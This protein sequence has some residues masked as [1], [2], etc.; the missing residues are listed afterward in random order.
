MNDPTQ[1]AGVPTEA[2][3]EYSADRAELAAEIWAS[4]ASFEGEDA[5]AQRIIENALATS[6]A[7]AVARVE[8][9][10]C[11]LAYKFLSDEGRYGKTRRTWLS[12]LC[13]NSEA[14]AVDAATKELRAQLE[15]AKLECKSRK[16]QAESWKAAW[17]AKDVRYAA[18]YAQVL[19]TYA[20][21]KANLSNKV[22]Q[23]EAERDER[24]DENTLLIKKL[25][26]AEAALREAQADSTAKDLLANKLADALAGFWF[27][28]KSLGA[29]HPHFAQ[30]YWFPESTWEKCKEA[31]AE[32]KKVYPLNHAPDAMSQQ[33]GGAS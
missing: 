19:A 15:A 24:T 5:D 2:R 32:A 3:V 25:A 1:P 6:E 23:A 31:L 4:L 9:R 14:A 21:D 33:P 20:G 30:H 29:S 27:T 11:D 26:Q 18:A 7:R 12:E 16:D 22:T 17:V 28:G 10:H 13:A 8:Q